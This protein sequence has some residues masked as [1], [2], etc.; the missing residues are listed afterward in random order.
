L[1]VARGVDE[2]R[3]VQAC[4]LVE[5]GCLFAQRVRTAM[6]VGVVQA[7]IVIH[8]L[9]DRFRLLAGRTIVEIDKL[10]LADLACQDWKVSANLRHT[11]SGGG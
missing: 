4:P 9:Q 3:N 7:I 10:A 6:Y 1:L 8:C 11:F 5:L 2:A